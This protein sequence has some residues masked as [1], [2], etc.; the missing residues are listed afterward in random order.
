MPGSF[1]EPGGNSAIF[2]HGAVANVSSSIWG[3]RKN[4]AI[5]LQRTFR[6]SEQIAV[7]FPVTPNILSCYRKIAACCPYAATKTA[8]SPCNFTRIEVCY[9][10][11]GL[12]L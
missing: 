1:A 9:T 4:I 8:S 6:E 12:E 11:R 3:R 10:H 5:P 7:Y 2:R